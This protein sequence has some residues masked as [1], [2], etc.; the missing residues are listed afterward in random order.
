MPKPK[1]ALI[2]G[3]S[4]QD[5]SYLA[6]L[7]IDKGYDVHGL[8]RRSASFNRERIDHLGELELHYGDMED[9]ASLISVMQKVQPDEI[10]NLAAQSH[11]GISWE[12]PKYT[13]DVTGVGVLNLLEAVRMVCPKA[14]IYQ[15]STSELFEG[16][17]E[18]G[19]CNEQTP[20][21]PKSPYSVAK[22]YAHYICEVYKEA[23][24]MYI[25]QGI[26]FNHES[27]RRGE[28]FV[29]RK[30]TLGIA[31]I[32]KGKQSKI[33]LGNLHARRDWGYAKEY[34][35]VMWKML[36]QDKPKN[37]VIATGESH[38]IKEFLKIAFEEVGLNWKDYVVTEEKYFR[39]SETDC[40]LGDASLARKELGWKPKVTFKELVRLM[41]RS[42]L[43]NN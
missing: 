30:I 32:K 20:F 29:T 38:S 31:N 35:E 21:Y 28:N 3:V 14:K 27:P 39:P 7:L 25:V 15:A 42:D 17:I 1:T 12:I 23:Y 19:T 4:G 18:Q 9:V 40:L 26:L 5:G 43:K 36:Q 16:N 24:G 6:E 8:V 41:V 22:L 34:V 37:Y 13:A 2:T 11:V 10:Y 33:H